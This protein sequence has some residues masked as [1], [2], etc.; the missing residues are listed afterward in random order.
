MT[1]LPRSPLC[2]G[3]RESQALLTALSAAHENEPVVR[4]TLQAQLPLLL[5]TALSLLLSEF[6]VAAHPHSNTA[7]A[8]QL[9]GLGAEQAQALLE[10]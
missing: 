8:I 1:H 9:I 7:A 4:A 5:E 6:D 10:R 2:P 3:C